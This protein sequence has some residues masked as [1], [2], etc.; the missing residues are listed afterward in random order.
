VTKIKVGDK[1]RTKKKKKAK[2]KGKKNLFK[3]KPPA[4]IFSGAD[5]YY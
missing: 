1:K 3:P 4:E 2:V 5:R